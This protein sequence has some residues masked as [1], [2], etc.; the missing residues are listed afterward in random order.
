MHFSHGLKNKYPRMERKT[1][2]SKSER[3]DTQ[4]QTK[5]RERALTMHLLTK[6]CEKMCEIELAWG[7]LQHL[8]YLLGVSFPA[9]S[10]VELKGYKTG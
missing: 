4:T 2:N 8:V 1:V 5:D 3:K 9:W 10:T 7:L 6:Q